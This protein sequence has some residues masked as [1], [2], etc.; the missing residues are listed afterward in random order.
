MCIESD[1]EGPNGNAFS[2]AL[3]AL[4]TEPSA[5]ILCQLL[6]PHEDLARSTGVG[7][8]RPRRM[9]LIGTITVALHRSVGGAIGEDELEFA[10]L[11]VAGQPTHVSARLR[12]S[13][14]MSVDFHPGEHMVMFR[15]SRPLLIADFLLASEAE[16]TTT[17]GFPGGLPLLKEFALVPPASDAL[18]ALSTLRWWLPQVN[19]EWPD[20]AV[21]AP[22]KAE[23]IKAVRLNGVEMTMRDITF[24]KDQR[25]LNDSVLNFFLQLVV[26]LV[27]P[28][29]V[30]EDMYLAS[31]FFFQK[32]TSGGVT[33]G[34]QGW[35]NVRRWTRSVPGGLMAQKYIVV[36]INE[37]NVHWW[38]AVICHPRRAFEP[39]EEEHDTKTTLSEAP[40]IVCLDSAEE[41]PPKGRVVGF[42]RGYI[43]REGCEWLAEKEAS[44]AGSETPPIDK[45]KLAKVLR[46][47]VAEVPKQENCFDC[48]VFTIEYLLHVFQKQSAL[49][50]LGLAPHKHWFDQARVSHRRRRLRWVAA[51]L[52]TEARSCCEPDVGR[53]LQND[54]IRAAVLSALTDQPKAK[55]SAPVVGGASPADIAKRPRVYPSVA[56]SRAP[57]LW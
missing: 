1:E 53:L 5:Q 20:A 15:V 42:L 14:V 25:C 40:R 33:N 50:G 41:A 3:A 44:G 57:G 10:L 29:H 43:W 49:A 30:R 32:L 24:L 19:I 51:K 34:E 55:R 54:E 31:T 35:H 37:Q 17:D 18:I 45:L 52:M 11:D 39:E 16:G 28:P 23:E 7:G 47:V 4:A 9:S 13:A 8:P 38:L 21:E 2:D 27:A 26:E 48:G 6:W 46:A 12:T 56:P 36:P 22:P